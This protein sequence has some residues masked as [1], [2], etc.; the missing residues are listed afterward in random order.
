M[1]DL[2]TLPLAD[3]INAIIAWMQF[4]LD[5]IFGPIK[6]VIEGADQILRDCLYGMPSYL[7]IAVAAAIMAYR[8]RYAAAVGVA[9]ALA[10]IANLGLWR[11]ATDTLSLVTIASLLSIL[12][13]IP[14]AVLIAE[15][16]AAK[17]IILPLL[18]YMQSTPAFVYLIPAVLFF[19]IGTV[20]GVIATAAFALPPVTRA[21]A[22]G[23]EQVPSAMIEAGTA[24]GATRLQLIY[25]VKVPLAR[26]YLYA[27]ISQ[28]IMMSLSMVVICALIGARGLGVEVV[29]AL[30]QMNLAK[31]IESGIAVVM[32]A[33]VLDTLCRPRERREV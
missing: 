4:G 17:A 1:T 31:G 18:D 7:M 10:F 13:G 19:G 5:G 9:V 3:A 33:L 20:P 28:C 14:A 23:L 12:L 30:T 22:V 27:G 25:K 8:R 26:A 29:T 16:R 2:P 11:A 15:N 6:V 24:F 21:L 32:L